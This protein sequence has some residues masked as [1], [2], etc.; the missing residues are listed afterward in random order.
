MTTGVGTPGSQYPESASKQAEY[1]FVFRAGDFVNTGRTDILVERVESG[2]VDGSMQSYIIYQHANGVLHTKKPVGSQ[3]A[4]AKTFPLNTTLNLMPG[5]I[6]D[7]GFTDHMIEGLQAVMGPEV[8]DDYIVFAGGSAADKTAP[9]GATEIDNEFTTYTTD[10]SQWLNDD[11]H[12]ANNIM[13]TRI[14]L[15]SIGFG[16]SGG[17][18]WFDGISG[19]THRKLLCLIL[20]EFSTNN[21]I[22]FVG[23]L[24]PS[25]PSTIL[26]ALQRPVMAIAVK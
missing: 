9:Q 25:M 10:Q 3:L 4:Y 16:C 6:N 5:D 11:E 20:E 22:G 17:F 24:H 21:R 18:N 23:G 8:V 2:P 7:D 19:F 1:E 26:Q 12:F 15:F 14:P 13:L